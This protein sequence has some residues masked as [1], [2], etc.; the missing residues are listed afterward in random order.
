MYK[1]CY[2]NK[3]PD[4]YKKISTITNKIPIIEIITFIVPPSI[5]KRTAQI[6]MIISVIIHT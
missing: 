5:N 6:N 3:R 2:L 4:L 1:C